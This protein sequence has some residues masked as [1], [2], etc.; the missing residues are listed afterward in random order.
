MTSFTTSTR[1][2]HWNGLEILP[3]VRAVPILPLLA[4]PKKAT[5]PDYARRPRLWKPPGPKRRPSS[6]DSLRSVMDTSAAL[7]R[8]LGCPNPNASSPWPLHCAVAMTIT[9]LYPCSELDTAHGI[10]LTRRPQ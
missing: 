4:A 3:H 9:T 7:R 8:G 1:T 5:S 2:T 6:A 10:S